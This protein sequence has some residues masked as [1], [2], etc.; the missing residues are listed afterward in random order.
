M[1]WGVLEES[2]EVTIIAKTDILHGIGLRLKHKSLH[3]ALTEDFPFDL[4]ERSEEMIDEAFASYQPL[5]QFLKSSTVKTLTLR[6]HASKT[7]L[8][9]DTTLLDCFKD[10]FYGNK[11]E[12]ATE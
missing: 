3:F 4:S 9:C 10:V 6:N 11:G 7:V 8:E 12:A 2:D 1:S 5:L